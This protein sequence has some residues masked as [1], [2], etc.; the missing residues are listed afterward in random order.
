VT[1]RSPLAAAVVVALL[2]ACGG[3]DVEGPPPSAPDRIRLTSTAF[4][5]GAAIPAQ[6]SCD[7]DDVS[8]P[9]EWSDVPEG[10]RSLALLMEDP[11]ASGGTFVHW[12]LFGIPP[13]TTGLRSAQVPADA[14]EGKNSF[15]D[16]GYGGPCP[17][18]DDPRHRYVFMLYALRS[19]LDLDAGAS[20]EEV[21]AAISDAA[22]ARGRLTGLFGR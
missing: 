20:P 1:R 21:R 17:P 2:A 9:L 11:D 19:P 16:E 3:D 18:E 7:G 14:R 6:F 12:S 13:E 4:A 5:D 10:T 15:G 22:T 8:P